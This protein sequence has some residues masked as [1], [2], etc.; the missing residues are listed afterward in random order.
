MRE[1]GAY[2]EGNGGAGI[3]IRER[4]EE[5]GRA[6]CVCMC[7]GSAHSKGDGCCA[8]GHEGG[9]EKGMMRENTHMVRATAVRVLPSG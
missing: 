1:I 4:Q 6:G 9:D 7:G 3:Y 8:R 2:C 5:D